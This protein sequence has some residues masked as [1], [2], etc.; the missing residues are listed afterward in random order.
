MKN[1]KKQKED[2]EEDTKMSEKAT[3]K[4]VDIY[5]F[6]YNMFSYFSFYIYLPLPFTMRK[7]KFDYCYFLKEKSNVW[8][9]Q[10][11]VDIAGQIDGQLYL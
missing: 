11:G 9:Q 8:N 5:S 1:W 2:K 6:G 10:K 7:A 4:K 3:K